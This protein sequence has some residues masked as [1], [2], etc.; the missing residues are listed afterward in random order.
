MNRGILL[1]LRI[2][3]DRLVYF[4]RFEINFYDLILKTFMLAVW[5]SIYDT[6]ELRKGENYALL[7]YLK[8]MSD[9]IL[10]KH[11][12]YSDNWI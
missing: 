2:I 12:K 1:Y 8:N 11:F 4:E 6:E 3:A 9:I 7:Q 5:V 10:I